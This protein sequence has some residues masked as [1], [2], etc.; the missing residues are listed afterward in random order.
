MD[1]H[2][3]VFEIA[4]EDKCLVINTNN[5]FLKATW[6]LL[7]S[8]KHSWILACGFNFTWFL[9]QAY[10]CVQCT[11]DRMSPQAAIR[12]KGTNKRGP[13]GSSATVIDLPLRLLPWRRN[14]TDQKMWTYSYVLS[15]KDK[16]K[17]EVLGSLASP[18]EPQ[19][20]VKL[21]NMGVKI[22]QKV[23]ESK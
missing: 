21:E 12:S 4:S 19:T 2:L 7:C 6:G 9:A 22:G 16:K 5:S 23:G 11:I 10:F 8:C 3:Q 18:G 20:A 13:A 14:H 17:V 1:V 15:Q